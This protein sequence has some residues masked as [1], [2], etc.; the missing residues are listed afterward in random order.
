M[1]NNKNINNRYIVV[2]GNIGSG[3]STLVKLLS[4]Y[5]PHFHTFYEPFE[6]NPYLDA[7]Y[8]NKKRWGF[9][10]QIYFLS[11][12]AKQHYNINKENYVIQDSCIDDSVN[13]FGMNLYN[14]GFMSKRD[15]K[16]YYD[17]YNILKSNLKLPDLVFYLKASE[18]TII[19]RIKSRNR[20]IESNMDVNYIKDLNNLYNAWMLE[21]NKSVKTI[22]I[23]VDSIDLIDNKNYVNLIIDEINLNI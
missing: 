17:L 9:N 13:I 3:K 15:W 18:N 8:K 23:D 21:R 4:S 11:Q 7:F 10:S 12:H 16:T 14:N 6:A 1:N 22:V 2:S 5:L 19:E 20:M